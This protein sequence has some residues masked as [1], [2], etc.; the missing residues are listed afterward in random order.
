MRI[1]LKTTSTSPHGSF[2]GQREYS[3]P[4]EMP[5]ALAEQLVAGGYAEER[6]AETATQPKP[7]EN[8]AER[9]E[10]PKR[11]LPPWTMKVSP[12][13]YLDRFPDGPNAALAKLHVEHGGED[14]AE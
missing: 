10:A 3:V 14:A 4:G 7:P 9:T 2:L 5:E 6:G 12:S 13:E 1:F 8:A 11:T